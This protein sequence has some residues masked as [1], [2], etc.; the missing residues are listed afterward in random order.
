MST[1]ELR[2]VETLLE[3]MLPDPKG[4]AER[5]FD[6]L[7]ERLS[8][9]LPQGVAPVGAPTYDSTATEVLSDRNTLFAAAV[10]ACECWGEDPRCP[11]C[12]GHGSPGWM[13][14]DSRLYAEYITPAVMRFDDQTSGQTSDDRTSGREAKPDQPPTE[15]APE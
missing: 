11:R 15:G 6:Q 8:S 4:F 12:S 5:V 2:A 14:P 9:D 1:T 13:P 10:G 3:R 7:V